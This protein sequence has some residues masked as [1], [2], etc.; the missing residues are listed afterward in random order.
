M[1]RLIRNTDNK[2][3]IKTDGKNRRRADKDNFQNIRTVE[4]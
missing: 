4:F 1:E 2:D 3:Q